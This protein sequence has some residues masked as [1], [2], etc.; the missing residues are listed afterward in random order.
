MINHTEAQ[1][2]RFMAGYCSNLPSSFRLVYA[3]KKARWQ[4]WQLLLKLQQRKVEKRGSN[5]KRI[6]ITIGIT[7]HTC[8][9]FSVFGL[10][11]LFRVI[12]TCHQTC[13][14]LTIA[15]RAA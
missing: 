12:A 7:C 8:H 4:V 6:E 1:Y 15:E 2:G 14:G 13:H 5:G 3:V 11:M 9:T 10:G